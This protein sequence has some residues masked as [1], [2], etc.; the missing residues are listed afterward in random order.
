MK[1]HE[2]NAPCELNN[3]SFEESKRGTAGRPHT[4]HR[5]AD[6]GGHGASS[7]VSNESDVKLLDVSVE[8]KSNEKDADSMRQQPKTQIEANAKYIR[9]EM[10]K[11]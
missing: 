8:Q 10:L 5:S 11:M 2:A 6:G 9:T 1:D 7:G 3:P 4:P